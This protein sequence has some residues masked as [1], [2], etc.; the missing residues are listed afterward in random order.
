VKGAR[1]WFFGVALLATMAGAGVVAME[2]AREYDRLWRAVEDL[3]GR[4]RELERLRGEATRLEREQVSAEELERLRMDRAAVT[5][6][7]GELATLKQQVDER[8]RAFAAADRAESAAIPDYAIDRE[9][10][11]ASGWRNR[12]RATPV[13]A[14]ETALWAAAGGDI[15]TLA[16]AMKLDADARV[17]AEKLL[18]D[19]PDAE[20]QGCRTPEEL[21]ALLTAGDVPLEEAQILAPKVPAGTPTTLVV[22]LRK[23]GKSSRLVQVQLADAGESD[24]RIVVP[25][26]AVRRYAAELRGGGGSGEGK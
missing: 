13:A 9:P 7:R 21:I 1:R 6:M 19:V 2:Q 3:R 16:K 23:P 12:G 25:A 22:Q 17:Q 5:R 24:W 11:P 14:V 4:A 8:T 18:A 15:E 26:A 10:V 20:R